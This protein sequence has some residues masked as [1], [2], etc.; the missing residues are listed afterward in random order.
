[1][2][3]RNSNIWETRI[4]SLE[5]LLTASSQGRDEIYSSPTACQVGLDPPLVSVSPNPEFPV[6]RAIEDS[7][8]FGLNFLAA[9]QYD[10]IKRCV[11]L[12]RDE[13][14]K[15][16]VLNLAYEPTER[17]TPLLHDSIEVLECKV[18]HYWDNG[19]HRTYIGRPIERRV[20][21]DGRVSPLRFG[22]NQSR[23]H[24][25][26]K[27]VLYRSHAYDLMCLTQHFFHPLATIERGTRD[28]LATYTPPVTTVSKR[29]RTPEIPGLCLVG[30]GWWGRV[31]GLELKHLGA[32][33]H[34]FFASRTLDRAREFARRFDGED[35]FEGLD[36]ALADPRVHGVVLALPHHLH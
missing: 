1:M 19:D 18:E 15:L 17:G 14:N 22:G 5:V 36:S 3:M 10:L 16:G 8:Y 13:P 33:V 32:R 27:R 35:A 4:Q 12:D 23:V 28:Q 34:R 9:S 29:K 11:D 6:C 26:I 7:G 25:R 2:L 21:D 31:H 24:L 30:C 20:L